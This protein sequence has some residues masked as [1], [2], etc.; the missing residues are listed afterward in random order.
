MTSERWLG[1]Y[2]NDHLS[3]LPPCARLIECEIARHAGTRM[4][5]C[6]RDVLAQVRQDQARLRDMLRWIGT[7]EHVMR[8]IGGWVIERFA[9]IRPCTER[10]GTDPDALVE[11]LEI[12]TLDLHRRVALWNTLHSVG[13][14]YPALIGIDFARLKQRAQDHHDRVEQHRL[15]A[16]YAAFAGVV[17]VSGDELGQRRA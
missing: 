9:R 2:L 14:L 13:H 10:N 7:G 16:A 15:E 11:A 3:D 17:P 8:K 6:L 12:I 1:Q 4:A 5:C